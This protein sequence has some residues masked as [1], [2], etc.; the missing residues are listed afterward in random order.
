M[1]RDIENTQEFD[2][3]IK[4]A[5]TLIVVDFWAP[6]CGPCR[7]FGP[8]L[9][10]A[11]QELGDQAEFV[12]LNVDEQ[13]KLAQQYGISSIPTV[14]YFRNGVEVHRA[15]GVEPVETI[16]SNIQKLSFQPA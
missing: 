11:A 4:Q 10:Q 6:W 8:I 15:T 5:D 12:K 16:V 7:A 9:E 2:S 13:R 14:I 1:P 3:V